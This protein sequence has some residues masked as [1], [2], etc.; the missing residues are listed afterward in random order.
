MS[1][2]QF[3]FFLQHSLIHPLKL[4]LITRQLGSFSPSSRWFTSLS[5][6]HFHCLS[7]LYS[8]LYRSS[9]LRVRADSKCSIFFRLVAFVCLSRSWCG[10][11]K[12]GSSPL[13]PEELCNTHSRTSTH[14]CRGW[15]VYKRIIWVFIF[16]RGSFCVWIR[17]YSS[18]ISLCHHM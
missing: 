2:F 1:K 6:H 7:S 4:A 8:Y 3:F 5:L 10:T 11:V 13:L 18:Q 14:L 12:T 9:S 15:C 17:V 16:R